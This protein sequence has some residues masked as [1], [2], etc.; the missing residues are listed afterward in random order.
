MDILSYRQIV[1]VVFQS[2]VDIHGLDMYANDICDLQV[3]AR[4]LSDISTDVYYTH[5]R[6]VIPS[7]WVMFRQP[8]MAIDQCV[9]S[10]VR[11]VTDRRML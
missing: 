8:Q 4:Y 7:K 6:K 10:T 1:K 9:K 5:E 2:C 11:M 3:L